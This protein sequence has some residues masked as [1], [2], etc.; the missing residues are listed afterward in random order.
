M[1]W[2]Y[3]MLIALASY[4]IQIKHHQYMSKIVILIS[5][6]IMFSY[7][8]NNQLLFHYYI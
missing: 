8:T 4:C 2:T 7:L 3:F 1:H 6:C 5:L